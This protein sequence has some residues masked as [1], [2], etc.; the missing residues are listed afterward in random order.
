LNLVKG[1]DAGGEALLSM[2]FERYLKREGRSDFLE[3]V[4]FDFFKVYN[5]N[6]LTLVKE[7]QVLGRKLLG[8]T[9]FFV[10]EPDMDSEGGNRMTQRGAIR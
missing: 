6:E 9:N 10:H 7:L 4:P 8:R 1:Q 5:E 2:M 3:Y